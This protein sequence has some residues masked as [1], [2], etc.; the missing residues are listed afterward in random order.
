MEALK[1]VN[2]QVEEEKQEISPEQIESIRKALKKHIDETKISQSKLARQLGFSPSTLSQFLNNQYKGDVEGVYVT[3]KKYLKLHLQKQKAPKQPEF[4][5]TETASEIMTVL[6]FALI[7]NDMGAIVGDPGI[8]KT[9]TMKKFASENPG[10]EYISI[11][12][13]TKAPIALLDEMLEVLN[14]QEAGT[15]AAKQRAVIKALKDSGKMFIIDEA[16]H[17]TPSSLHTL[18]AIHDATKTPIILAGNPL[19]LDQMGHGRIA[20]FAQLFS[21]IGIHRRITG[22]KS[23]NDVR[24]IVEQNVTDPDQEVINFLYEKANGPG[25]FR[26]MVKHLIL[27]MTFAYKK[28]AQVTIDYLYAAE[29]M[30]EGE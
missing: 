29:R 11:S 25:G 22:K 21:R 7:N 6:N 8:G 20:E 15:M 10:V 3:A 4:V 2:P 5:M 19:V 27:A 24:M 16:Q 1:M 17:L 18:Q 13:A 9:I 12:P 26:Y 14:K 28:N 23:K 30:L